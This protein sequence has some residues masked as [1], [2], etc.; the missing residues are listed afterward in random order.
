MM[1]YKGKAKNLDFKTILYIAFWQL[2]RPIERLEVADF[3][4]N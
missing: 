2:A 4:L 3:S 1:V